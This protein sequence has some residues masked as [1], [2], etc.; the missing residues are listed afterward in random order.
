MEVAAILVVAAEIFPSEAG[1]RNA[2][3]MSISCRRAPV[4]TRHG[5]TSFFPGAV[6]AG[7]M[8]CS[9]LEVYFELA[10]I[11]YVDRTIRSILVNHYLTS[12]I[13]VLDA[14]E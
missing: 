4:R 7:K 5:V 3:G 1:G 13:I 2:M 6:S 12:Q 9:Q 8:K 11:G 10:V 14:V